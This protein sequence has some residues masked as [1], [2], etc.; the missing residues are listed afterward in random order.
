MERGQALQS[1]GLNSGYSPDIPKFRRVVLETTGIADPNAVH[2]LLLT[3]P[4]IRKRFHHAGTVT[5][6]DGVFG[7]RTLEEHPEAV[8]QVAS[9]DRLV[10]SKTDKATAEQI[11]LLENQL[12]TLNPKAV[13]RL[14]PSELSELI[15]SFETEPLKISQ[16]ACDVTLAGIRGDAHVENMHN[17]CTFR[18]THANPLAWE[19]LNAWLET[20]LFAHGDDIY[21]IK[22]WVSVKCESLPV[23]VQTV[24]HAIYPSE[25]LDEWPSSPQRTDLTF[26][27]RNFNKTAAMRS[28]MQFCDC[29]ECTS[30]HEHSRWTFTDSIGDTSPVRSVVLPHISERL[31]AQLYKIDALLQ[32]RPWHRWSLHNPWSQASTVIDSWEILAACQEPEL[33]DAVGDLIGSDLFLCHQPPDRGVKHGSDLVVGRCH[34]ELRGHAFGTH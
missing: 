18:V 11:V 25:T 3:D 13:L 24:R 17:F 6:V 22:G 10:I 23:V 33:L 14:G 19:D 5:V 20:L 27:C 16:G 12:A 26:I 28:L 30:V 2:Q 32:R 9:G 31:T 8:L 34:D 1:S 4:E 29:A 7:L 21:R 15:E